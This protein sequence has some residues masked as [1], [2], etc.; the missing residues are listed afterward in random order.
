MGQAVTRTNPSARKPVTAPRP[1][2]APAAPPALGSVAI[3]IADVP[4][5]ARAEI[6]TRAEALLGVPYVWGGD[7]TRGLDCSSFLSRTWNVPRQ[8][9]DTLARV[10]DP[11]TKDQ[12]RP[13]DAL[14]L[15]TWR[16][17][18]RY[19]HVRLFDRWANPEKTRVWVYEETADTGMAVHRVIDYDARY[20]PMRARHLAA[21]SA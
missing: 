2:P 16:D 1:A 18:E 6:L 21:G 19:G 5:P 4:P 14:N 9:T 13:G 17:P 20:Q 3:S 8:T 11:I 7:S 12:L 15:P 10:A